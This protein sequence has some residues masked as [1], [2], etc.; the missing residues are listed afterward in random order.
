MFELRSGTSAKQRN[1]FPRAVAPRFARRRAGGAEFPPRTPLPPRPHFPWRF[2][3]LGQ[4]RPMRRAARTQG[5]GRGGVGF[6]PALLFF[7]ANADRN[8]H[9]GSKRPTSASTAHV[10][11]HSAHPHGRSASV[12]LCFVEQS[13][14][15]VAKCHAGVRQARRETSEKKRESTASR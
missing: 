3:G 1:R 6:S 14:T 2:W 4:A 7:I 5:R 10:T 15:G 11:R 13:S 8:H 12:E 9:C